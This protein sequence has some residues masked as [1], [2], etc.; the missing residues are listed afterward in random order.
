M[1]LD[2]AIAKAESEISDAEMMLEAARLDLKTA[3]NK[4]AKLHALKESYNELVVS[5]Q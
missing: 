5:A 4:L 1:E 2:N 3:R